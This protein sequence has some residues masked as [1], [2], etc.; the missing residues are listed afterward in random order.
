MDRSLGTTLSEP[1]PPVVAVAPLDGVAA[2]RSEAPATVEQEP[3][4]PRYTWKQWFRED[5]YWY[6]TSALVHAIGFVIFALVAPALPQVWSSASWFG[7]APSFEAVEPLPKPA[8]EVER[9]ELGE[10]PLEPSELNTETLLLRQAPGQTPKYYDDSEVFEEEGGGRPLETP[11]PLVGGLGGF[12]LIHGPGLGGLG[13]VG[14][15]RGKSRNPG[16]GGSGTG[17]GRGRGSRGG[18]GGGGGTKATERAVAAALY[19]FQR[20]QAPAGNWS[21]QF[22]HQCKSYPC[23]GQG[24]VRA[25]AAATALALLPFL[26]AGQTH[27]SKGPF[28]KTV[29]RGIAWLIKQQKDDG[30][31]SAGAFQ[32][33]YSHGLATIVLCEA[34]GMTGDEYVGRAAAKGIR[35]IEMAQ[36]RATGGWRYVPGDEGDTSVVGW[37]VMALKSGQ[38]A[39][40]GG[41]GVNTFCLEEVHKWL[42]SVAKGHYGGLFAYQPHKEPTPSMTAVALLCHQYLGTP[43]DAPKMLEAKQYLLKNPPSADGDRDTYYWYYATMALHNFLDK[44][45]DTWNRQMRRV[46]ISTQSKAGCAEGSWDPDRPVQDRWGQAG[47]R[48]MTTSLCT[49]TLEVYYRYLPLFR[50]SRSDVPA[51]QGTAAGTSAP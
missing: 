20:H 42:R 4:R 41:L 2:P 7:Q 1:Y 23:S 5:G 40:L 24:S 17:F 25:D 27:K 48:L 13:G 6:L 51:D 28:Q 38:M 16:S 10:A 19:W 44:D 32:P 33:M 11:G 43:A 34:Y 30:D 26:A 46:L 29:N 3:Q 37:Q 47:G 12:R 50:V 18:L 21:L 45:W 39:G 35:F 31:L 36:N 15:E 9:Y 14:T 22:Q 49:L 8:D